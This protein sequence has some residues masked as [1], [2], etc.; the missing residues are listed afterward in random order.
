MTSVLKAEQL[1]AEYPL[2]LMLLKNYQN[3]DLTGWVMSEKLDGIRGYWDGKQLFT[4]HHNKIIPPA[5]FLKDFPP[6]TIHGELFTERNQFEKISSI[7]RSQQDK[8]WHNIKLYVFDVPNADGDLFERLNVLKNYLQQYPSPYIQIIKQ[9]PINSQQQVQQFLNDI[10]QQKGEGVVLRNPQAPYEPQRSTQI[11][12]LK[13]ALDKEC[14]VI[15]HHQGKGQFK[16]KLGAVSCKNH[17]GIFK[18]SSG[19]DLQERE[20]PPAINSVITYKYRGLTKN[21]LPKF[22]TYWRIRK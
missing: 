15:A 22:A 1:K 17:R 11:L 19:F 4:R 3:Q 2:T 16:N 13:T 5:Y 20:N 7:V 8:G 10:T 18:I 21:G 6:F 9:T 12:K 14:T